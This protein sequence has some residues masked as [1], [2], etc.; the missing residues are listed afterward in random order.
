MTDVESAPNW[1]STRAAFAFTLAL[2]FAAGT[3]A[4]GD[5]RARERLRARSDLDRAD[6]CGAARRD[7]V[8]N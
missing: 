1:V 3:S 6:C 8:A 7:I 2:A 4:N 5:S